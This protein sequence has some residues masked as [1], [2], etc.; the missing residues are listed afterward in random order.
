ML[1]VRA[2]FFLSFFFFLSCGGGRLL[3]V[4]SVVSKCFILR[5][6]TLYRIPRVLLFFSGSWLRSNVGYC[7]VYC[8]CGRVAKCASVCTF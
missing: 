8:G 2:F 5:D 3:T 1:V 7:C 4:L 6:L